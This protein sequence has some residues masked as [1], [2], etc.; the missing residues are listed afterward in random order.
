SYYLIDVTLLALPQTQER[1]ATVMAYVEGLMKQPVISDRQRQQLAIHATQLKEA[2]LDRI[3]SSLQTALNE[4]ANFY[5]RSDTLQAKA[6]PALQD[7]RNDTET[8]IK[9]TKPLVDAESVDVTAEEY[10]EA[11][12]QARA[13]SFKLWRMADE[14]LDKLLQK[15]IEAYQ[16]N[17]GLSLRVA[18]F[19]L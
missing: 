12:N 14:E 4:D 18:A 8:F 11:G 6:P 19:A 16:H 10:L 17:R 15:R 1:L 3:S 7:Y 5:G 9:L 2:D 13:T